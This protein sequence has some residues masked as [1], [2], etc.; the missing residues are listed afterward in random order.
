MILDVSVCLVVFFIGPFHRDN[1]VGLLLD[2]LSRSAGV[3]QVGK[4][5]TDS[6]SW[7][8]LFVRLARCMYEKLSRPK[9]YMFLSKKSKFHWQPCAV[10]TVEQN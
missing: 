2:L 5:P 7:Q 6:E 4:Y 1:K 10:Q 9:T 8:I 3:L